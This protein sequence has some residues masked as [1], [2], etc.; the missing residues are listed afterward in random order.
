MVVKNPPTEK[1][2]NSERNWEGWSGE[3]HNQPS[4]LNDSPLLGQKHVHVISERQNI[5]VQEK[6]KEETE[7]NALLLIKRE[8][9]ADA[10][11]E[12]AGSAVD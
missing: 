11:S 5:D 6:A 9:L 2:H 4:L 3:E 12:V 1:N 10:N 7:R 8:N